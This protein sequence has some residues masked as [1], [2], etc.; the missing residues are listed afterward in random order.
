MIDTCLLVKQV[1]KTRDVVHL[2]K[3]LRVAKKTIY[4]W[5]NG[6]CRPAL[7]LQQKLLELHGKDQDKQR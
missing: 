4:R 1:L 7:H 2:S 5:V 3:V 6:E